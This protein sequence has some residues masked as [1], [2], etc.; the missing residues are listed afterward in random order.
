ML[1]KL[2][3][4]TGVIGDDGKAEQ[5]E[6]RWQNLQSVLPPSVHP[7]TGEYR[8]VDGCAIDENRK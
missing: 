8:W 6:F 2:R 3:N 7:T 5:L 1:L 4:Q